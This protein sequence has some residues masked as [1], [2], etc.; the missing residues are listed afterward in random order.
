MKLYMKNIIDGGGDR[1]K[2]SASMI[3]VITENAVRAFFM[4]ERSE[5]DLEG[6]S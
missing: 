5:K 2:T 4:P 3:T 6:F 1:E